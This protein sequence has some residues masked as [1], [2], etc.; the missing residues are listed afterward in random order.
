MSDMEKTKFFYPEVTL[1]QHYELDYLDTDIHKIDLN[2][3]A[4][5]RIPNAAEFR[6]DLISFKFFGSYNYGWLIAMHND[7]LDPVGEFT[8]GKVIDIP[9]IDQY[10]RFFNANSI[11]RP[12]R[13]RR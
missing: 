8:K 10:F 2:T 3:T 5:F 9:D 13:T 6:P 7:F 4:T 1:G 11:S 12:R